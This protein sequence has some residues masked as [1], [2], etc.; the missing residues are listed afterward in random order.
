V[1]KKHEYYYYSSIITIRVLKRD[2]YK[3]KIFSDFLTEKL[4]KKVGDPEYCLPF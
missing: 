1:A 4:Y 3:I 2:R